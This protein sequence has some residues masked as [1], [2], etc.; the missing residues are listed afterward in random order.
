M[1]TTPYLLRMHQGTGVA[2]RALLNDLPF[3]RGDGQ[4]NITVSAPA[5]H[6]LLPGENVLTLEIYKAPRPA[7]A[8][9]LEGPVTF[10]LMVHDE[11]TPVVHTVDWPTV[12]AEVPF[13]ERTLPFVHSSRFLVDDRLPHPIYWDSP[14]TRFDLRGLPGQHEAVREVYRAF[15]RGDADAFI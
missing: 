9:A 11:A 5:N 10:T 6:L 8:S 3:Y 15:Q 2:V 13:K 14:P 4:R 1:T 12:W 7:E